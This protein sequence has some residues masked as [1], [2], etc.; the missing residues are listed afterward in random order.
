MARLPELIN[1][2]ASAYPQKQEQRRAIYAMQELIRICRSNIKIA[3]PQV[4]LV[5]TQ[6]L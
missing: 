5:N 1:D 4:S 2:V 6:N 3:R